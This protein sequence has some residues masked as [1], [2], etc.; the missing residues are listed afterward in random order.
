M[1]DNSSMSKTIIYP[2][3]VEFGDCDPARIVWFPNF[4]RWIDAASRHFFVQCGVP[5]WHETEQTLGVIGTPLVD[6]HARFVKTA[7][8]GD[9]LEIH[10]SITEW[11]EKSFVMHYQIR[12]GDDLIMEC[13]EVRIFAAHREGANASQPG[14]RAVA[15]PPSIRS[16]CE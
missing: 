13:D 14:I 11:R 2:Q 6:T 4:F 5:S 12:R 3:K 1:P 7:S 9:L 15:I 16:L 10:T 8:Y